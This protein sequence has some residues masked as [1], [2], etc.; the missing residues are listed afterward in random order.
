MKDLDM[1]LMCVWLC[2]RRILLEA[3]I[4]HQRRPT[5]RHTINERSLISLKLNTSSLRSMLLI[6]GNTVL[7]IYVGHIIYVEL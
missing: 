1:Q 6:P 5:V 3:I 4:G 7:I 2:S